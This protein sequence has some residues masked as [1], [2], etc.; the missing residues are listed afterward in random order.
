MTKKILLLGDSIRSG[1]DLYVKQ[2]LA[3]LADVYY[4]SENCMF[5][6]YI[7]RKLHYWTDA[8]GLREADAVHWNAGLWDTL[9]IYGD[10]P[11]TNLDTYEDNIERIIKRIRFLFPSAKIIFATSTPVIE[12][13]FIAEFECRYNSDI[14]KY[15]DAA[16]NIAKKYGVIIN[17]LYALL[18]DKPLCFHSDQTHFYTAAA[19]EI[20]GAQVN[21]ILCE[22]LGID[23]KKLVLPDKEQFNNTL[24]KGDKEL[25]IKK[26]NIYE[27]VKGI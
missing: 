22:A 6:Q 10:K 1:Y 19:T 16:C 12:E 11:L 15:N 25:Y 4:P 20:I 18:K 3:T 23:E 27:S 14:E 2:S 5:T 7:L 9:R 21:R 17:D 8:M 24:V 26:G 13:G